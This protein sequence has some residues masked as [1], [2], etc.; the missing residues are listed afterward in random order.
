MQLDTRT[1]G[2][3]AKGP[4]TPALVCPPGCG[5]AR[6]GGE[7]SIIAAFQAHEC[8]L[9]HSIPTCTQKACG[10]SPPACTIALSRW[11]RCV[12]IVNHSNDLTGEH[13]LTAG[14]YIS[15]FRL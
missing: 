7:T 12:D 2:K 3:F 10:T 6:W 14:K 11:W 15:I 8:F 1:L 13:G 4:E 5:V 9:G